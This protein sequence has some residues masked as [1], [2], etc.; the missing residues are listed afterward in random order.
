MESI[1]LN[2]VIILSVLLYCIAYPL[3]VLRDNA[4]EQGM[5]EWLGTA[6]SWCYH[7]G[8]INV[9]AALG[10]SMMLKFGVVDE[11]APTTTFNIFLNILSMTFAA[12]IISKHLQRVFKKK[13]PLDS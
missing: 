4:S 8:L 9:F 11:V 2:T 7:A 1:A 10:L 5:K 13:K 3:G 12:I 6:N